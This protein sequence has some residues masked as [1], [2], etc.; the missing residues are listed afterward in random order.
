MTKEFSSFNECYKYV[1]D[2]DLYD[3]GKKITI[4][5]S[6]DNWNKPFTEIQRTYETDTNQKYFNVNA[7]GCSLFGNCLDG[8][9][10]GVRLDWYNW[11]AEKVFLHM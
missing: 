5:Y 3:S 8:T 9:D 2:N 4:I 10:L 1:M 7:C 6:Q 11:K